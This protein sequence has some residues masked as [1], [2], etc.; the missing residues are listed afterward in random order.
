MI[1]RKA[2]VYL[3]KIV[4]SFLEGCII[5]SYFYSEEKKREE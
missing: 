3:K 5:S 4:M 2:V 1:E